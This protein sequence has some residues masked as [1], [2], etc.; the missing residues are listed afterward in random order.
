MTTTLV[1]VRKNIELEPV[2]RSEYRMDKVQLEFFPF[3]DS[4]PFKSDI[5][6]LLSTS[7]ITPGGMNVSASD[8]LRQGVEIRTNRHLFSSNQPKIWAGNFEHATRI[9]TFGQFRSWT[10]YQNSI[11]WNDNII[12]FNPVLYIT[13]QDTY[14]YPIYFNNGPQQG[15]E[16]VIE[17]LTSPY[18]LDQS[19]IEGAWPIHR[20]KGN[21]EEGNSDQALPYAYSRMFQFIPYNP[22]ITPN[23]FLDAGQQ[24]LGDGPITDDIII[25]GYVDYTRRVIEPFDDTEDEEIVK[26]LDID[27][28]TAEGQDFI[29]QLK[30]LSIE[31]DE[32]IRGDYTQKSAA[33]GYTV[34]GPEQAR[35]GTDSVAYVGWLRGS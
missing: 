22:P 12:D 30:L 27:T 13:N 26:Q 21:I 7:L 3:N 6:L 14:P 15:E 8:G 33:A 24:Y 17:P 18:R 1:R 19:V 11:T 35:Y 16:A 5:Q 32:D 31:L 34:Y 2:S 25:E 9:T 20:P 29:A 23:P 4:E 10:E 28:S